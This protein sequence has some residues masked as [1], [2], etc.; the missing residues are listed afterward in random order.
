MARSTYIYIAE[1]DGKELKA[2]TVKWE[3]VRY[4]ESVPIE[5][6][7]TASRV[8]DGDWTESERFYYKFED[9]GL[10]Q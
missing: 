1:V 2:F 5:D 9:L 8:R 10:T 3:M 7:F 6:I 4:L